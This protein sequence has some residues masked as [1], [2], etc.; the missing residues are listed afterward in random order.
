M[1]EFI[2]WKI[3]IFEDENDNNYDN[4]TIKI[5]DSKNND[6]IDNIEIDK[7]KNNILKNENKII[8]DNMKEIE[9]KNKKNCEKMEKLK[10]FKL[11]KII[12]STENIEKRKIANYKKD[13]KTK[14]NNK[15]IIIIIKI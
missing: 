4:E 11:T 7:I 6:N 13:E 2:E 10:K 15:K 12:K 3:I 1:K 9:I 5:S 8:R 14:I